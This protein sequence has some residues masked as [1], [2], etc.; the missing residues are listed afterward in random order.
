MARRQYFNR[1]TE[2]EKRRKLRQAE[3]PAEKKLWEILRGRQI[4]DCKFRRQVSI[5]SF[6]VDF[7]SPEIKLVVELDGESHYVSEE[8]READQR[9]QAFIESLGVHV[10]RFTNPQVHDE[11]DAV[12]EVIGTTVLKLRAASPPPF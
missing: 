1:F 12:V 7:Y 6:V 2:K 3:V 9:R 11:L 10:I 5:G 8:A 4:Y